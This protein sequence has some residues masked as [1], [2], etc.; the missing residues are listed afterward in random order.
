MK[1]DTSFLDNVVNL[2]N[3]INLKADFIELACLVNGMLTIDDVIKILY[4]CGSENIDDV[5]YEDDDAPNILDDD[6]VQECDK[7][8]NKVYE[9]FQILTYRQNTIGEFYPF[10]VEDNNTI[11]IKDEL[12]DKM[13]IYFILL[14][15]SNITFLDLNKEYEW[16]SNFERLCKIIMKILIPKF[17]QAEIFGTSK[18]SKLF[19]G[20]L[21][22]R[23]IKLA[24]LLCLTTTKEFDKS[25][26]IKKIPNGDAGLDIVS[27]N[28]I[29][30]A[31]MFPFSFAQCTCSFDD[32]RNKQSS[33]F[34]AF[35]KRYINFKHDYLKYMFVPFSL[36]VANGYFD[37]IVEMSLIIIDRV[38]I[39]ELLRIDGG[40]YINEI[41]NLFLWANISEIVQ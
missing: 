14:L 28:P 19:T 22:K 37:E 9:Y 8:Y 7:R 30:H 6:F 26:R 10:F 38:R 20:N 27:W 33:I 29:D 23:I 2:K 11:Q 1:L 12:T 24:E 35:W 16:R 41:N 25:K 32:W 5:S 4:Y 21:S 15:C 17:G 34:T 36:H 39:I 18:D 3:D 31:G 40:Q 13:Q